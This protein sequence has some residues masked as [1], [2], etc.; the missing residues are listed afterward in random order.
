MAVSEL[1]RDY[2]DRQY[3]MWKWWEIT[4]GERTDYRDMSRRF[5]DSLFSLYDRSSPER[6]RIIVEI[7][8]RPHFDVSRPSTDL[9]SEVEGEATPDGSIKSLQT[10]PVG[11]GLLALSRGSGVHELGR[12]FGQ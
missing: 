8:G 10:T 5:G 2:P 4:F 9:R 1:A 6:R 12:S 7:F 3:S 11:A